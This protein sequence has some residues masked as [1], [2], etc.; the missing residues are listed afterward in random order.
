MP[1][2][3]DETQPD[4]NIKRITASL[5][6]QGWE[7]LDA[8]LLA[9]LAIE[10]PVLLIGPHGT[11][12]TLL[13]ERLS[14]ALQMSFRHY[15]ASLLN[16]DDLVGIPMPEEG[17]DSLRFITTPGAIWDAEFVFFDEI[18][19]CRPDLQNKLFP[20]VHERRVVGLRLAKLRYRWAAMNPPSPDNPEI[21]VSSSE[22]YLG[23]EPLDPALSDRF[24][25][26]VPV[27]NWQDLSRDAQR[28]LIAIGSQAGDAADDMAGIADS[29]ADYPLARMV[30][31]VQAL[32][33]QIEAEY[34]DWLTDYVICAMDLLAKAKLG[35]SPRRARMLAR[36]AVA[37]HAAHLVIEQ[38]E[39]QGNEQGDDL[40]AGLD[41]SAEL[42]LLYGLPQTATE[43]PPTPA[44]VVAVHRQAWE[45]ANRLD[46]DTWRQVLEEPD[47]VKRVVLAEEMQFEDD[48]LAPLVTQ[49]LNADDSDA[50]RMGLAVAMFLTFHQHRR[51]TPAAWEPLT[52]LATPVLRPSLDSLSVNNNNDPDLAIW[53]EIRPWAIKRRSQSKIGML[54]VNFVLG[55]FPQM[56][57]Q[58]DWK[59]ALSQFTQDLKLFGVKDLK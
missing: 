47:Q 33:P 29:F 54:E 36:S 8:V 2:A 9:A 59:E 46:D 39:E 53:N 57:R 16:Y 6:I 38:G 51:L 1:N 4:R 56:W 45:I 40:S 20:I 11:A 37:I 25:F 28:R 32:I 23:S 43:A 15:N 34:G 27:P 49:A 50:R 17:Q 44:S 31:E 10:A 13:V 7:H 21:D 48:D 35:Q 26:V 14:E 5:K 19:R 55:G 41:Y 3:H 24:P 58:Y 12:K 30:G 52:K 22:Y 18:S 42:A